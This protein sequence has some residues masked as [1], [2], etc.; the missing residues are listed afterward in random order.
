MLTSSPVTRG[1][2]LV[3]LLAGL[4]AT[5][6]R[7][8]EPFTRGDVDESGRL[9]VSDAVTILLGLFSGGGARLRCEAA[10]DA[11]DDDAIS[12]A[13]AI[14][15]LRAMFQGGPAP[16]APF[17][18]CGV[19]ATGSLACETYEG[20]GSR[21]TFAQRPYTADGVYFVVDRSLNTAGRGEMS[22]V[23]AEMKKVLSE[24]AEGT[25]GAFIFFDSGVHRFPGTVEPWVAS[26]SEKPTVKEFIDSVPGG[27]I[28]TCPVQ[29]FSSAFDS[30]VR[31]SAKRKVIIFIHA[32]HGTCGQGEAEYLDEALEAIT[33]MNGGTARIDTFSV[34]PIE[35][36]RRDFLRKLAESNGGIY[37][38]LWEEQS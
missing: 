28:L 24:M 34:H 37:T 6:P 12:L 36:R 31:G 21:F 23:R 19:D 25:E 1:I 20:C 27:D 38:A 18:D 22:A 3:L 2:T 30:M 26:V 11:D 16:P 10:A 32:V 14:Y 35:A 29:A 17:P 15:I 5:G 33:T 9:D 7:A 13:D 8:D 4:A